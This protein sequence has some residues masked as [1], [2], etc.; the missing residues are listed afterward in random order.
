MVHICINTTNVDYQHLKSKNKHNGREIWA[1]KNSLHM[2]K[3][4]GHDGSYK[5]I[6]LDC[7]I[8]SFKTVAEKPLE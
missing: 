6:G 1:A 2:A 5:L 8:L 4:I 3:I 7:E